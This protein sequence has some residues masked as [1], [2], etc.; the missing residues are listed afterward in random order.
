MLVKLKSAYG[1]PVIT[2]SVSGNVCQPIAVLNDH[3]LWK[4]MRTLST[5][6][7]KI[8]PNESIPG[9]ATSNV[10]RERRLTSLHDLS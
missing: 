10:C 3:F 2:I 4:A 5:S 7:T 8:S 6:P 1:I 9:V